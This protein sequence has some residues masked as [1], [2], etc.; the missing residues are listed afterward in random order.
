M[1]KVLVIFGSKSDAPVYN[2][3]SAQL[4]NNDVKVNV[5]AISAHRTPEELD[6]VLK[7]EKYH[8]IIAGAGL[9]AHLPGVI[10][11]KVTTPV[12]GVPCNGNFHGLD[13]LLSI[14]QMPPG[15]PVLSVGVNQ[16]AEAATNAHQILNGA[17]RVNII[18][19]E[20]HPRVKKCIELLQSFNINIEYSNEI[21]NS[22]L[23]IRFLWLDEVVDGVGFV[24]HVPLAEEHKPEDSLRLLDLTKRGMWVGLN[25]GDNAALAAAAILGKHEEI[26][27][28]RKKMK[29]KILE[30]KNSDKITTTY[31]DA[32]VD[33]DAGN[34]AV[35][36]MKQYITSTFNE[37]VLSDV[38]SFGGLYEFNTFS[39]PVLVSSTDSVGTKVRLAFSTGKHDTIGQ[40]LVNHCV[41]DILVQGAMPLFFLDYIGTGKANPDIAENIVKGIS[42]ACK[43]NNIALIGGELA[44]LNGLY[45]E[46]EY[47]LVGTVVGAVEKEKIVTGKNITIGDIVIGF[48]SNGL[49]TNGYTLALKVLDKTH[50]NE[51]MK[52]HK[53]YLPIVLAIQSKGV[54]KGMAHITGGGLIEN[55]PRILPSDCAVEINKKS[56]QTPDIF[57]KIQEKGAIAE[58]EMFRVFNMGIGFVI[59]LDEKDKYYALENGGMEIGKVVKGLKMVLFVDDKNNNIIKNQ[60]AQTFERTDFPLGEKYEGKVRDNYTKENKRIIIV[61]DKISAF[62]RV[63]TTIPFK[64]QVLNQMAM[65]WFE[66]TKEF[67]NHMIDVPDPNVMVVKQ[68]TAFP[69]E[70]VV[71]AYITGSTTTSAWYNY[72]QGIRNFCGN[73][74][75]DGMKKN[76]K[77]NTP[78]LTPSTKAVKGNHDES[79][80]KD[81][82]LKRG[83][84][85]EEQFDEMAKISFA[86]FKRGQ[87]VCAQQG[88]I[89]VDTKYEFG[90]DEY[91]KIC[92]ID[93]IHTPDSSRFWFANT[94]DSLFEQGKEQKKIDKEYVRLWLAEQG[95]RGDGEIPTITDDVKIEAAKRYIKAYE[96]IT[97]EKFVLHPGNPLERIEKNL[98][99]KGYING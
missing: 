17:D 85:T 35:H 99:E 10:A 40:D 58:E 71:R 76:Q 36:R 60:I 1:K 8:V 91:G 47:D 93:E 32:G 51:L 12:I 65:F 13:S 42:I 38:G 45:K 79:V 2:K 86:L 77:F 4:T 98:K 18:G 90:I 75:P 29:E 48:P 24:I 55:I 92:I 27:V 80:S 56:W 94:Y 49:H 78:I 39:N 5:L 31:K 26:S 70:M 62:D 64:G 37:H 23:N 73:I 88:I 54:I 25:R 66:E 7:N 43:E 3:I 50:T 69:V 9:A 33:I 20:T 67:N 16:A 82:I 95:F 72:E 52:I 41:N 83:L 53:S 63:L 6:R 74:L 11:S 81:E 57:K 34:D 61:T 15:I 28:Y 46:N 44:E 96:L 19:D 68:C 89:L 87:E 97:G 22:A 59:I 21:N 84:V 14:I 30:N